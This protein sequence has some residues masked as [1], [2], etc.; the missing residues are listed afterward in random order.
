MSS[1]A[2]SIRVQNLSKIYE[3]Y[4]KP[5]DLLKQILFGR[6]GRRYYEEFWALKNVSFDV[7]HGECVGIIGQNGAGKSTLLQLITGTLA[8]TAGSVKYAGRIGAL[9]ELGS[10]FNPEIYGRENVFLNGAILGLKKSEIVQKYDE[11]VEFAD[12]G[13]FIERPV[14]TYSSGMRVRLAFAVQI[15][16]E[17]EILI[18]DEALSV[19]DAAFQQ[20]CMRRMRKYMENHTVLFVSHSMGMVKNLCSRAIYLKKGEM[21]ADGPAKDVADL[22]LRDLYAREQTV[23][24]VSDKKDGGSAP[25]QVKQPSRWRDMRQDF[26]NRTNLRNDLE[27]FQFDENARKFGA[28]GVKIVQVCFTDG[29]GVPLKWIVGGET[30]RLHIEC[31][32]MHDVSSPIIGFYVKD[33]LGQKLFGDNTYLTYEDNS[34]FVP[35]GE[36]FF[37]DFT[38]TM[39]LLPKGRY[40]V[41]AAVAEGTQQEHVQHEWIHDALFFESHASSVGVGL[42][43]IP[44]QAVKLQKLCGE[45]R[46]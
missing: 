22:Y 12:I 10:G 36:N 17:P 25:L 39:P 27:V 3:V 30:V 11:I 2:I 31:T 23:S 13:E 8:A 38:F 45:G 15:V 14:K 5:A 1:D 41:M 16:T 21:V 29:D 33:R 32:A 26:I 43:G 7:K 28:G 42:A 44:M 46:D 35:A 6:F 19:G 20:K 34:L 37:A 4:K 24:G 40:S 18:V 9:L